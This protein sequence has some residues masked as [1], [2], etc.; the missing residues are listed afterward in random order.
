MRSVRSEATSAERIAGNHVRASYD[1]PHV[2]GA[3]RVSRVQLTDRG[4]WWA[5]HDALLR[6]EDS[7]PLSFRVHGGVLCRAPSY[8]STQLSYGITANPGESESVFSVC[9]R[10]RCVK[11]DLV[12]LTKPPFEHSGR[13]SSFK[14]PKRPTPTRIV[15]MLP[16]SR[17]GS[18]E[19]YTTVYT[20]PDGM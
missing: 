7:S 2:D 17:P 12:P 4:C 9:M 16:N 11:V 13:R 3:S 5:A 20:C 8:W 14:Q 10:V 19:V 18:V 6:T 15:S 1:I